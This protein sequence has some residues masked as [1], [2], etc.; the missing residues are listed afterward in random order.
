[1]IIC[2]RRQLDFRN[3]DFSRHELGE[4]GVTKGFHILRL[5]LLALNLLVN[6]IRKIAEGINLCITRIGIG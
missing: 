4:Q 3:V 6:R 2:L 1:M 5:N